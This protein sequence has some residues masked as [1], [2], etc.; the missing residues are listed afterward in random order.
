[1]TAQP[2]AV[3]NALPLKVPPWSPCSKQQTSSRATKAAEHCR[4]PGRNS[5]PRLFRQDLQVF[6]E[7]TQFLAE[8]FHRTVQTEEL[9]L[10]LR[11]FLDNPAFEQTWLQTGPI[12]AL[13][14]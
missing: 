4:T 9:A 2:T 12:H 6:A 1:M 10:A 8:I 13:L 11:E 14:F 7:S 3:T 5:L